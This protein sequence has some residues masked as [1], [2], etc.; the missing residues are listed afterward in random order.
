MIHRSA[1]KRTIFNYLPFSGLPTITSIYARKSMAERVGFSQ[2][3][4]Y[5]LHAFNKMPE[6]VVFTDIYLVS[7]QEQMSHKKHWFTPI[8]L[9][10]VWTVCTS[11]FVRSLRFHEFRF[12]TWRGD[13]P[14]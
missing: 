1:M 9:I 13:A 8:G 7:H 12:E 2:A 5:R 4:C 10:T 3:L 14:I 6:T 11:V